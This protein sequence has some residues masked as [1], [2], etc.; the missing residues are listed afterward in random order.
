MG[1]VIGSVAPLAMAVAV[2]PVPIIGVILMLLGRHARTTSVGYAFGWVV[3]IVVAMT[4]FV[5]VGEVARAGATAIAWIQVVL[6]VVLFLE[7][8]RQWLRRRKSE[9]IQTWLSAVDGMRPAAGTALGFV[10][11]AMNPKNLL[12]CIAAGILVGGAPLSIASSALV[13]AG[14]TVI[15]SSSVVIPVVAYRIFT[16]SI[17]GILRHVEKWLE[18]NAAA[19]LATLTL[20]IGVVL[21]G[22]GIAELA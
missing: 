16:E 10:L 4:L 9:G 6:G 14:F 8:V 19:I 12:L 2:S 21:I 11:A 18:S 15:A 13:I 3:G 1:E 20:I 7:G 22:N 17:S 5:V